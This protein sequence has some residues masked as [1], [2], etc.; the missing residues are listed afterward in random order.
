[1]LLFHLDLHQL[2]LFLGKEFYEQLHILRFVVYH[3][4][5]QVLKVYQQ[6]FQNQ[7]VLLSRLYQDLKYIYIY[8]ETILYF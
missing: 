2:A 1:M 8:K 3:L 5:Q 7:V 6:E 4:V